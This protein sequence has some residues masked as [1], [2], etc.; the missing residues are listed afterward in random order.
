MIFLFRFLIFTGSTSRGELALV[1]KQT[2][3][4]MAT[5]PISQDD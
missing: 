4:T 3:P 2:Q 1:D 5:A